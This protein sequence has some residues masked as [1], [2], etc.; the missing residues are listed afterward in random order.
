MSELSKVEQEMI[1]RIKTNPVLWAKAYLVTYDAVK[2]AYTPWTARWYQAEMLQDKSLRKVYRCGRRT[3]KT[4][5][6]VIEALYHTNTRQEFVAMFVAPYENQIRMIFDRLRALIDASPLVKDKVERSTKNPYAIEFKGGSKILG[7]TTGASSNSGAASLRG[8]RADMII[9]D[10]MDYMGDSD[11]ENVSML[12]AERA[13]ISIVCSSTPTG[14]R[15]WFWKLCQPGSGYSEHY[16]PSMHNPNWN[17]AM[18]AEFR[19]EMTELGYIHE[20]IADFGPQDTG[21]FNKDCVDKARE[22][23]NFTY[24]PL[25]QIQEFTRQKEGRDIP[26]NIA[27]V[28]NRVPQNIF[29]TMAVDWD[30]YGASSSILILDFDMEYKRFRVMN[31]IEVPKS[32]Y[33]YDNAINMIVQLNAIYNPSWIYIDRGSGEYQLE[34][35][36]LIGDQRPE[37]GLKVKVKGFSFSNK[38]PI[39]DPVKK[40]V[41]MEPMKPFMVN[42]LTIAFERGRVILSP[43]DDTLYKQLIDYSVVRI[44]ANGQPVF[45]DENEHFVD[46]LGLAYLAFVLEFPDIT[47]SVKQLE[48][49]SKIIVSNKEIGADK[50]VDLSFMKNGVKNP[51]LDKVDFSER[52]GERQT[53][54]KVPL[55]KPLQ[56]SSSF[57][58]GNRFGRGNNS[59][60]TNRRMF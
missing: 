11:F 51:W 24:S 48:F 13:D 1:Q 45:T 53:Y 33:T 9:C 50:S 49:T 26:K 34:R 41:T 40:T 29:R 7:F 57:G 25:T 37:T 10:E 38:L 16:H 60:S 44:G 23:D 12:A 35:L 21:V 42:Q 56:R 2:K 55:G 27:P 46:C 54:F 3:G 17:D 8:Q 6:M 52:R 15:G 4:E 59:G 36:H 18:E 22:I 30:K 14:K 58:W 28:G 5:T 47:K 32:E 43:Y 31:R 20:I 19:S 39:P